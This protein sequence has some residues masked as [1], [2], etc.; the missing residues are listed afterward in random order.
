[1]K[2]RL[3]G[4]S[5]LRVSELC[6]G[7]M[8]FGTEWGWGADREE[9]QKLL[10]V[11]AQAGGQFLDTANCYTEGTSERFLG[12]FLAAD[13]A[14]FVVG[15]KYSLSMRRNDPNACGNHRKNMIAAL[16]GS[17]KRLKTDYVDVFWVHA[18]DFLTPVEEVMRGLDD[19]VRTGKVLYVGISD[20]PAWIVSQANTLA[21][22]RGWSPFVGLQIQYSLMER[23]PERDLLPMARAFGLAVT[24]WRAL[25]AGLLTGKYNETAK[26]VAGTNPRRITDSDARLTDRNLGLADAVRR[27][28][29][30]IGRTPAQVALNWLRQN[31]GTNIP[32]LGARTVA[33]LRDNLACLDFELNVEQ[34]AFLDTATRIDLGFPHDFLGSDRFQ[35]ILFGDTLSLVERHRCVP[36]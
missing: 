18:W 2:Y 33:Q 36:A 26:G 22:L 12:D 10:E 35:K 11:F 29:Q 17:L 15:T 32:I 8:T 5:G 1:M 16:E 34:L 7:T 3:F 27:F 30:E 20:T 14:H 23:T 19:L 9:S 25:G 28:A 21:Q 31:P 24:A 4:N 13:R 6:L